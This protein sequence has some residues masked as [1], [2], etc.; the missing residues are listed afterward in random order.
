MFQ[1]LNIQHFDSHRYKS[2]NSAAKILQVIFCMAEFNIVF[3][4]KSYNDLLHVPS[5]QKLLLQKRYKKFTIKLSLNTFKK[6]F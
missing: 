4:G 5:Q 3:L 1:Y 6:L 2:F